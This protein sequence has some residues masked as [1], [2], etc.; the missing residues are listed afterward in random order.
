[1]YKVPSVIFIKEIYFYVDNTRVLEVG[2]ML[3]K[4]KI[5]KHLPPPHI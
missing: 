2:P 1:M 5:N 3:A 4:F